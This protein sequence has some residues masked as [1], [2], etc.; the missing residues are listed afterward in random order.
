[1]LQQVCEYIH[2]YF[3]PKDSGIPRCWHGEYTIAEDV[4][5]PAPALKEGQRFL[6]AGSDLNDGVYTYHEA[7]IKN[8]DDAEVAGLRAEVFTGSICAMAVPPVVMALIGEINDWVAKYGEI[9]NSPYSSESVQGVYNYSKTTKSDEAG[10][11]GYSWQDVFKSRL[12][13]WRKPCP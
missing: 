4:I 1:M 8:D 9:V 2:N 3:I 11:G 12:N 5:S 10:G 6:I 13:Q 7:G